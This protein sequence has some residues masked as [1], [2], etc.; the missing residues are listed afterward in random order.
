MDVETGIV[1]RTDSRFPETLTA[2][3]P[4]VEALYYR[5]KWQT[6]L[7]RKT[8]AVVGSRKISRY[9]K[10]VIDELVPR[11]V[12]D[13]L[14]IVSGFMYGV[15]IETHRKAYLCGGKTIAVLGHGINYPLDIQTNDLY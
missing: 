4:D 1:T 7:F 12:A 10:Q 13:G 11:L 8:V 2:I 9:G 6:E 15:D 5:G 3:V 14:T